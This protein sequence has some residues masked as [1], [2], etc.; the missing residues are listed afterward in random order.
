VNKLR[1]YPVLYSFST[2]IVERIVLASLATNRSGVVSL[3]VLELAEDTTATLDMATTKA[4]PFAAM[5]HFT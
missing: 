5:R 2:F 4:T 1:R 3:R